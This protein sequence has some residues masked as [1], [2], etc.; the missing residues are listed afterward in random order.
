MNH[1]FPTTR[2]YPR[3]LCGADGAFPRSTDYA[4]A[5]ER[6]ARPVPAGRGLLLATLVMAVAGAVA[7]VLL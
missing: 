2:S 7:Q 6:P 5:V 4:C 1:G 3:T